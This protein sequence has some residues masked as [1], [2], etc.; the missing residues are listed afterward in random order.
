MAVLYSVAM[1]LVVAASLGV[2]YVVAY[3]LIVA[4][5]LAQV[6]SAFPTAGGLY[7][8]SALLGGRGWGWACAMIC[9]CRRAR[10]G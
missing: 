4:L 7:H 9:R 8:W 6:A 5:C 10:K 3:C 1:G 2:P